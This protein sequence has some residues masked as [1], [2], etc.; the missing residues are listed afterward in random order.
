MADEKKE[1][2]LNYLALATVLLA[3]CATLATFKGGGFSTRSV[4]AQSQASNQ[5][6]YYQSKS[7]KSYIY[8]M[9][10]DKLELELKEKRPKLA[11]EIIGDYEKKIE[12]YSG[13][14]NKYEEEK[15]AIEKDAKAQE[16]IRD[17]AQK[18]SQMFGMAVIFLQIAILLSSIAALLKQK[19]VWMIGLLSGAVGIFYFVN[20]FLMVVK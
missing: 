14:I 15:A 17:N 8:E 19:P 18:H 10:K 5:W 3:V 4:L 13:K 20:G 1:P 7:I 9:Q 6:A 11:P 2:W 12:A 16:A